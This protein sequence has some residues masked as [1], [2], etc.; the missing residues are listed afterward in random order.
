MHRMLSTAL[1]PQK[2]HLAEISIHISAL[3]WTSDLLLDIGSP[4]RNR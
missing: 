4:A 3:A 2:S 1:L